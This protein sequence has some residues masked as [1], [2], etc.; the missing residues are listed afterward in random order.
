MTW[1]YEVPRGPS[2]RGLSDQREPSGR[3]LSDRRGST[4]DF[5][6]FSGKVTERKT[7]TSCTRV[8]WAKVVPRDSSDR[9]LSDPRGAQIETNVTNKEK[10]FSP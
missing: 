9:G 8:A 5:L 4:F 7:G 3:G 1:A 10:Q 6:Y 2:D